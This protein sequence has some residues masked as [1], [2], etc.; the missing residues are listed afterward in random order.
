[1]GGKDRFAMIKI[2]N[3]WVDGMGNKWNVELYNEQEAERRSKSLENCT[4]CTD[5]S[6]CSNCSNCT[7]CHDCRGCDKCGYCRFVTDSTYC[8]MCYRGENLHFCYGVERTN[9]K[10]FIK[11]WGGSDLWLNGVS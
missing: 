11:R 6:N 4:N 8:C 3:Y 7:G 2:N 9:D 5:C 1:M 10:E